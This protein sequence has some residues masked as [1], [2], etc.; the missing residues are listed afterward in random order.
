MNHIK[1]LLCDRLR[2][3][4]LFT[5]LFVFAGSAISQT[6]TIRG[7]VIQQSDEEP[8]VG[9]TIVEK[10][11]HNGTVTNLDGTFSINVN[12][13]AKLTFSFLGFITQEISSAQNMVVRM[14]EN[15]IQMDEV[16]VTGYATERKID[17]TGAVSVVKMD[18][19]E[20]IPNTNV[21]ASLQGRVPGMD[22]SIDGTPGDIYTGALIR[23]ITTMNNSSPLYVIDGVQTRQ[24][25]STLLNAND[26]ESI[27][28]LKDASSASIYGTQAAN[29]V[30]I[31]TTK[32]GKG[33]E[34]LNVSFDAKLSYQ[35]FYTKTRMLNARQW[36][37]VYWKA[38][39]NVGLTPSHD[40]YGSGPEPLIPE[41]IDNART[42]P[43]GDTNWADEVYDN[44]LRQ[45]YNVSI[46]RGSKNGSSLFS[47]NYINHDGIIKNSNFTR[48]NFRVNSDYSLINNK[49]RIGE[50]LNISR[51]DETHK[52]GGIEELTI[53]QHPLVPVYD[54]YGGYAGPT[55]GIGAQENPVRKL[56]ESEGNRLERWRIF[57]NMFAEVEPIAGL[58]LKSNFGLNFFTPMDY[59]FTPK[60]K[61]GDKVS[62]K[63]SLQV[64]M[65][66][67]TDWIWSNTINYNKIFNIHSLGILA[68]MEARESTEEVLWGK[69]E[70]FFLEV[71]E[72]RYLDAG[73]GAQYTGNGAS[74]Y[75]MIS[76]F[77]KINYSLMNRY[78]VS[79]T[80]RRDAS[81]RF[82]KNNNAAVFPAFS[83]GWRLSE[84]KFMQSLS[85]INDL[86]I[87][88]SWGKTGNDLIDNEATY[89]KYGIS[90]ADSYDIGGINKGVIP[91]G[92]VKLR[93]QRLRPTSDLTRLY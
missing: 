3:L 77:G 22:V 2:H 58:I 47:L 24:N 53:A 28:V 54:I 23:G 73:E 48:Y 38:Y 70:N 27:Q 21:L 92:I 81:S 11:T 51:Y 68:G 36:G 64:T 46:T 89:T 33:E 84:E 91:Y 62:D 57:G 67:N 13:G 41:F 71:P 18:D 65:G 8:L 9:V 45:D 5:A 39:K 74:S 34:K 69:K 43:A 40:L 19:I 7:K 83:A 78:L 4:L 76:Y 87:R 85:F 31:I 79:A 17:I 72:Y 50:N 56:H 90:S 52:P 63:N 35:T 93:K 49:L 60:W 10:G 16:V 26:V 30:I 14:E 88:G 42:I 29:G 12:P 1:T 55:Q 75:R 15:V 37:E 6:E 32:K 59:I 82:G 20:G 61:E 44:A 25:I 86:K 80:V 66:H